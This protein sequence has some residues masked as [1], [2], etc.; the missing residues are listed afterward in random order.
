[1]SVSVPF[2][3]NNMQTTCCYWPFSWQERKISLFINN[4]YRLIL[5]VIKFYVKNLGI[6]WSHHVY[7]LIYI[8][9]KYYKTVYLRAIMTTKTKN[10]KWRRKKA[11]ELFLFWQDRTHTIYLCLYWSR[12]LPSTWWDPRSETRVSC[13][14][15]MVA[16]TIHIY[17]GETKMRHVTVKIT[18]CK[19]KYI[20]YI[21]IF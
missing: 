17:D 14:R 10:L 2:Y 7:I 18:V 16:T 19:D 8:A 6:F 4:K 15:A 9:S 20:L 11:V 12:T 13:V 21:Y 3:W 5:C 1:M